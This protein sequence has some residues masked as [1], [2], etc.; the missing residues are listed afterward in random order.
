M[1]PD[2]QV[3]GPQTQNSRRVVSRDRWPD[4]QPR[5]SNQAPRAALLGVVGGVAG[6]AGAGEDRGKGSARDLQRFEQERRVE[7]D[8]GAQ[9]SFWILARK[10]G[11]GGGFY[12][13]R[14]CQTLARTLI[15]AQRALELLAR[16]SRTRYTRCPMPM[17]RRR[18]AGFAALLF[19]LGRSA[20]WV[21]HVLEQRDSQAV[22][23]PRARYV[24]A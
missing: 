5:R 22:L 8:V 4:I 7:L 19:A 6:D 13:A 14:E 21:A 10:L 12:G 17:M 11:L 23:R 16:G 24:G 18:P 20:G 2:P 9:R 1:G 15:G 3:L